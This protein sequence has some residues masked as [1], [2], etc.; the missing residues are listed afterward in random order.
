MSS[1]TGEMVEKPSFSGG[2]ARASPSPAAI[3]KR[4]LS[5]NRNI[6]E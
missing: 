1:L 3:Q 5:V 6:T 4:E 2:A